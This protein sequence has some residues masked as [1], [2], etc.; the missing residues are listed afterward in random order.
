MHFTN[1]FHR[2]ILADM[3][4]F[5][6]SH[7]VSANLWP[8]QVSNKE[9]FVALHNEG[10]DAVTNS[11][12]DMIVKLLAGLYAR[13]LNNNDAIVKLDR[14]QLSRDL[15][16][17]AVGV[18]TH[19]VAQVLY[20]SKKAAEKKSKRADSAKPEIAEAAV[21]VPSTEAAQ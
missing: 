11:Q 17:E 5:V 1:V 8:W 21:A 10:E 20:A 12:L 16:A 2:R 7:T 9:V 15:I 4:N 3:Q 18:T 14:M 19:N 13:E 6:D